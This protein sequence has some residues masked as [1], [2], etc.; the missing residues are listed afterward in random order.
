MKK[1]TV[2]GAGYVI[3]PMIDYFIDRCKYETV[4]ATRTVSKA[5]KAVAGR[6]LGK[7]VAWSAGQNE[8]LE[9]MVQGS[10]AV[11]VMIPRSCHAVVAELCLKHSTTMITTDFMHEGISCYDEEARK[12]NTLILTELGEDPGLD[13]MGL[14]QMIDKVK[15]EGGRITAIDSYGAGIPC[16]EHNRNPFGYKFSWDPNGLMRSAVSPARYQVRGK[17][18]D[19]P[20]KFASHRVVDL[21]GLGTFETYPSNDSTRYVERLGLD[22]DISFFKG[23]LR[24]FGYCNTMVDLL[25]IGLIENTQ[26]RDFSGMS[27]AGFLAELIGSPGTSGVRAAVAARMGRHEGDD[28]IKKLAW[29]GLFEDRPVKLA[30]GTN[31]NLLVDLMLEKMAYTPEERDMIIVH[32][33]MTVELPAGRER[34]YQTMCVEGI[35]NG[36]SAMAR[37]VSLPPAIAARL[38]IEGKITAKGVCMPTTPEMYVP[39]LEEMGEHGFAFKTEELPLGEG[40]AA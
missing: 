30:K 3:Q 21:R 40:T 5:E 28:F 19:V 34:R 26:V 39:I 8:A 23:L 11:M 38:I 2:L 16:F 31:S 18:V 4:V 36:A 14:A 6:A 15:G 20:H 13:N 35:P 29:L 25:K 33:E 10:D 32:N 17:P 24:Y 37:A 9:E 1:V 12:T 7:A 27:Y 22:K